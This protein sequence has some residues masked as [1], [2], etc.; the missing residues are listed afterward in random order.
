MVA[1]KVGERR[2]DHEAVERFLRQFM[3][4]STARD[5]A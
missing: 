4:R 2:S 1:A 3:E 5:E